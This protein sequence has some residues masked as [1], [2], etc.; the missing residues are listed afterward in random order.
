MRFWRAAAGAVG[1]RDEGGVEPGELSQG[2][3]EV[4]LALVG[5]GGKNSNEKE[6]SPEA[7]RSSIRMREVQA[8]ADQ[9]SGCS[10]ARFA[11]PRASRW[12]RKATALLSSQLTVASPKR[13][14]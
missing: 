1:D 7:S 5:R 14:P 12:V 9:R 8:A 11:R 4:A 10:P 2:A 13:S 6:G 3:A